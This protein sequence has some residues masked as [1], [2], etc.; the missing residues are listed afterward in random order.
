MP[1]SNM[2]STSGLAP[3]GGKPVIANPFSAPTDSPMDND[4]VGSFSTGALNTGIGFGPNAIIGPVAPGSIR[5]AGFTDNYTPGV[6][7]PGGTAATTA[8]LVAIGGGSSSAAA[9][10]IAATTPLEADGLVTFGGGQARDAVETGFGFE[11]KMV[12]ATG[13]VATGAAIEA[14]FNN[15]SG[16]AMKAGESAFGV[17]AT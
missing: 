4:S 15:R 9:N 10:G 3:T 1:A 7:M 13:A 12:T 17:S 5:D 8:V 16:V 2:G 14:G 11:M 6:T